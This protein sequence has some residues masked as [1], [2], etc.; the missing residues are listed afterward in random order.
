M[1]EHNWRIGTG[2]A[3]GTRLSINP[4]HLLPHLHYI[5]DLCII[6]AATKIQSLVRGRM[7]REHAYAT[8]IANR[9]LHDSAT[10]IQRLLRGRRGRRIAYA[11]FVE[12]HENTVNSMKRERDIWENALSPAYSTRSKR[13]CRESYYDM[14]DSMN[15]YDI[16]YF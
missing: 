5:G 10:K 4:Y 2:S 6:R 9:F 12:N 14:H 3:Y 8:A 15:G 13:R 16:L 7:G 1:E 11:R